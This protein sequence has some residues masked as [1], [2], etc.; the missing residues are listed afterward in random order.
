M[1][2]SVV[3]A[4]EAPDPVCKGRARRLTMRSLNCGGKLHGRGSESRTKQQR[5]T[6]LIGEEG[7]TEVLALQHTGITTMR[8]G[9]RLTRLF[10]RQAVGYFA[11]NPGLQKPLFCGSCVRGSYV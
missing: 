2:Y 3:G 4:A 1:K 8:D 5:L 10:R 7:V 9:K 11:L 6:K